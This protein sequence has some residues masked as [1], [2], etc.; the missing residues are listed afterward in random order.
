[1]MKQT[2]LRGSGKSGAFTLVEMLVVIGIISILAGLISGAV[3]AVRTSA[4]RSKCASNLR[5][6]ATAAIAYADDHRGEFPWGSRSSG[7]KTVCW[8]FI[9]AADGSVSPGEMWNGYG[10]NAVLQ[11]PAYLGGKSNWKNNPY[12]G[13]NYNCSFIGKVQGDSGKRSA[14]ARQAQ[15]QDASRTALFGDGQ[16]SGGANKFM[17]APERDLQND[18]SSKSIR[19]SGTQGFRHGGKTNVAFCDGHVETLAQ[20]YEYGGKTGFSA[21]KCG[22][23]SKDNRLYS[24]QK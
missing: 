8:D 4:G 21:P 10:V 1:M 16:Y 17:R 2:G 19:L 20:S 13:Y 7:G 9:V 15:I 3:S 12:T 5:M 6:M 22:F 24:L 14:P 23:L 18:G 11:C